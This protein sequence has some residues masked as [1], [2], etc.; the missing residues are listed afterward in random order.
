MPTP[1]A[2]RLS[3]CLLL[4]A[5]LAGCAGRELA[6]HDPA[7]GE[8]L[9]MERALILSAAQRALGTPYRFGGN[10]PAAADCSGLVQLA[11]Q[12]AG[13][14]APRTADDPVPALPA[15]PSGR[16]GGLLT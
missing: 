7:P 2:W 1:P 12:A 6:V 14:P 3:L 9:S 8:G 11:D 13:I 4:L 16:P 10:T 15:A 5:L